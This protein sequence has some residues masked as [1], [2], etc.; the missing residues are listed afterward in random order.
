MQT[1]EKIINVY[2]SLLRESLA[3]AR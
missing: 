3:N 2:Y 1:S